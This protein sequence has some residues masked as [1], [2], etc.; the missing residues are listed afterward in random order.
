VAIFIFALGNLEA[1]NITPFRL[2]LLFN[3]SFSVV[4]LV[5]L[6]LTYSVTFVVGPDIYS[7]LFCAKN[8]NTARKSALLVAAV[9]IPVSFILTYIGIFAKNSGEGIINFS[10]HLLP[11]WAYGLFIAALLSAVMSSADTTLLT[12]SIILSE[13]FSPNLAKRNA[14]KLTRGFVIVIG[15][16]SIVIALYITSIIQALLLALS[17]FSGAFVVPMLAALLNIKINKKNVL[18]AMAL[19][20]LTALGG[21]LINIYVSPQTGNFIIIVSYLVNFG[22]LKVRQKKSHIEQIRG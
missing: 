5:V 17:F 4:D 13:L 21:K 10:E 22:A 8:E 14:L 3:T 19:G 9:L 7:R 12:A 15:L 20:G 2:S 16:L 6:L 11:G 1:E 18:W